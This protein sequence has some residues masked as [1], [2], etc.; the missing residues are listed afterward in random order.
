MQLHALNLNRGEE[1]VAHKDPVDGK[2]PGFAKGQKQLRKT[3]GAIK[4]ARKPS[5]KMGG[6]IKGSK[7][8]GGKR[9]R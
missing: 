2:L 1:S 8:G 5:G 9:K 3:V 4:K 7:R 6:T